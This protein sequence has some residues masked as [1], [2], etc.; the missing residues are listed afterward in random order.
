M[1]GK[2]RALAA[3]L[4]AIAIAGGAL[5]PR[6]LAAPTSPLGIAFG[7][8]PGP[9]LGVVRAPALPR[10]SHDQAAPSA[11]PP[12]VGRTAP[13][14]SASPVTHAGSP[15]HAPA[16]P[17]RP[18]PEPPTPAPGPSP[19]PVPPPVLPAPQPPATGPRTAPAGHGGSPVGHGGT[20]PGHGGTP[21]GQARMPPG[22][23]KRLAAGARPGPPGR[24][25]VRP[26]RRT[27]AYDLEGSGRGRSVQQAPPHA[28]GARHRGVG[29]L[30]PSPQA[31]AAAAHRPGQKARPQARGA[32]GEDGHGPPQTAVA[33][34]PGRQGDGQ[35]GSGR[36]KGHG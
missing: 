27:E 10:A 23:L 21:P 7:P 11:A 25:G 22:Q 9:G 18:G 5:L 20:P 8:E 26:G 1:S 30:A 16:P 35:H 14:P 17:A 19:P 4:L 28:V 13:R 2:E 32:G 29:H 33:H 3:V 12:P 24:S 15:T 31:A 6:M 34:G 36:G